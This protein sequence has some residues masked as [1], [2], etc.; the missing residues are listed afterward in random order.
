M[1]TNLL[2]IESAGTIPARGGDLLLRA[3]PFG[4]GRQ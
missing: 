1:D 2:D 3:F 4:R